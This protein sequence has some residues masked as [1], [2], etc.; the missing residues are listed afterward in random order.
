MQEKIEPDAIIVRENEL[1][2]KMKEIINLCTQLQRNLF[3]NGEIFLERKIKYQ[4]KFKSAFGG[5]Q[6]PQIRKKN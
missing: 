4:K 3:F 1:E 5:F 6:S 2:R